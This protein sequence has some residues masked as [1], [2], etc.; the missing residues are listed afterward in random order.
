MIK[1]EYLLFVGAM[2]P[3]LLI[4]AGAAVSMADL[5]LPALTP[6]TTVAAPADLLARTSATW[7]EWPSM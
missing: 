7:D 5:T 2:V 1:T 6:E 4:L 3:S